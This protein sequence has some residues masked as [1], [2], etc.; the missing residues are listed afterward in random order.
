MY[1]DL[2]AGG[3]K[4]EAKIAGIDSSACLVLENKKGERKSFAFKEVNYVL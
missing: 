4:I 3:K 2:T 1:E